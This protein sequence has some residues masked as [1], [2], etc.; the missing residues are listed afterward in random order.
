M[1]ELKYICGVIGLKQDKSE[2]MVDEIMEFCLNPTDHGKKP[3]GSSK[4]RS[5][6]K[7]G[8]QDKS[9]SGSAMGKGTK[10]KSINSD[11]DDGE[12]DSEEDVPPKKRS[13][14]RDEPIR[15]SSVGKK[16]TVRSKTLEFP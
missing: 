1:T 11:D 16:Y 12:G 4:R 13:R 3:K 2:R 5:S 6:V 7:K 9:K 15:K 10:R 14:V 8:S